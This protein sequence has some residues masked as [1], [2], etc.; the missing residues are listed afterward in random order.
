MR[1][2]GSFVMGLVAGALAML[3]V[4]RVREGCEPANPE[5]L[6]DRLEE[7]LERL[8]GQLEAHES[9]REKAS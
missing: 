6:T 8:E 5:I 1:S 4:Q 2:F 9:K 3:V 7:Q